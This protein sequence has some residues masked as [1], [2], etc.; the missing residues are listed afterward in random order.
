MRGET[1]DLVLRYALWDSSTKF[2]GVF[3]RDLIPLTCNSYPCA[4]VANTDPS[5]LHGRH[6][7]VFYYTSPTHLEFFDSYGHPPEDYNFSSSPA[8]NL[9]DYNSYPIQ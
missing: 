7:V 2:L 3:S 5:S 4:F 6:W 9:L 8:L 1:L